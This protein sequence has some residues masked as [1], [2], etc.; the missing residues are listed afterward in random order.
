VGKKS[1]EEKRVFPSFLPPKTLMALTTDGSAA[2]FS[3][4]AAVLLSN[5]NLGRP[6]KLPREFVVL[7]K[8]RSRGRGRVPKLNP[9]CSDHQG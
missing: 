8:R 6:L 9:S 5:S 1:I 2:A 3:S 4:S 7:K